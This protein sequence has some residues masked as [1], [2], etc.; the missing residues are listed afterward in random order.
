MEYKLDYEKVSRL[1]GKQGKYTY[2]RRS[3]TN[4]LPLPTREPERAKFDKGFISVVGGV[5]RKVSGKG[6][7]E[8]VSDTA[9]EE[10]V[11]LGIYKGEESE[12]L[13]TY[14][15]NEQMKELNDGR[16]S[17]FKQIERIPF[18][19]NAS[20]QKGEIDFVSFFF[21][22][23]I[24]EDIERVRKVLEDIDDPNLITEIMDYLSLNEEGNKSRSKG[25]YK[26]HFPDLKE[27]FIKDISSLAQ[28]QSFILEN[29]STLFVHYTFVAMS[30]III[31]TNKTTSFDK[32]SFNPVYYILQW[33]KA[34]RW[35]NS[36]TQGYSMLKGEIDGFFAHEHALNII[37]SNTFLEE[38][39]LFYH[40][41]HHALQKAGPD[42][43][44]QFVRSIYEW[45]EVE[46]K[47]RTSIEVGTYSSEKTLDDAFRDLISA[48]RPGISKEINSRYQKAYEAIVSKF[49][50]KHG[51][52]LGT[53]LALTQEQL[54]LLVA[55]SVGNE[56]IELK[57][58]W[59][60]FEKRGVWLDHHSKEE[61]VQVL[62]KLNYM[63]KKSDSGD[64]QYV[65]SIL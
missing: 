59:T 7:R 62:D 17:T 27:Q 23:F 22:T 51:G 21:D 5:V 20:E 18:A 50:R 35:R 12:A 48:I 19:E 45:L 36:Y 54:L 11:Q 60:E 16:I 28:N 63:E 31:Q 25:A 34:A 2:R 6:I 15:L 10:L 3:I 33:E 9:I 44:M 30:Q 32:K 13:F 49:F 39:N 24:G 37:G 47:A 14:Y 65:K 56:R 4:V 1:T 26:C 61:V 38:R 46:Y 42:A 64:A 53:L 8:D 41:I 55:V 43:E 58:L 57:Q 40:D 29:I 52:S